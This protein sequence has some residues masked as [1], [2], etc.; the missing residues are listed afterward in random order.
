MTGELTIRPNGLS[1]TPSFVGRE[2]RHWRLR[3]WGP[4]RLRRA[5][6]KEAFI[7]ALICALD[8]LTT[9][10]WVIHGV[11]TEANPLLAWTFQ[12]H[13]LWFVLV[14]GISCLPALYLLTALAQSR[15]T[16]TVG[17]LR[18]CIFAYLALY[19]IHVR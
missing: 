9:L 13:P 19:L 3:F 1:H 5:G 8:M 17:L 15:P 2:Q 16:L 7:L 14:K 11:A 6:E 18:F 4:L 12:L 10:W